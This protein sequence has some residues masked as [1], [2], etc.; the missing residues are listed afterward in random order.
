MDRL[1]TPWRMAYIKGQKTPK[2]GCVFCDKVHGSDDAGFVLARSDYVYVTLNIFPYSNGHLMIVPYEHIASQEDM[3]TA[4]LTDM[5]VM[6]N[7]AIRVLRKA[8]NPQAFNLGANLGTAAGA[9]IAEHF[10]FHVVPRWAGDTNFM[11]VVGRTRVIPD[12]LE[13]IYKELTT[14]WQDIYQGD[15]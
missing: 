13:N 9:G 6:V 7:R 3:P 8:Y 11:T 12:S 5:M 15:E 14:I 4:G 10:H 2:R 1:Y